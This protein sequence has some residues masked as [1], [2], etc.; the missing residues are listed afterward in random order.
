MISRLLMPLVLLTAVPAHAQ[1]KLLHE[2]I[3]AIQEALV[4][5]GDYDGPLDGSLAGATLTALKQFQ[6]REGAPVKGRVNSADAKRLAAISENAKRE[7]GWSLAIDGASDTVLWIPHAL[8]PN[9][10]NGPDGRTF[11]S[12]DGVITLTLVEA[13]GTLTDIYAATLA[14]PEGKIE[15][16]KLDK[17]R[18]IIVGAE[19]D[20]GFFNFFTAAGKGTKG[21]TFRYPRTMAQ[22]L[23]PVAIA[24]ANG[25]IADPGAPPAKKA[26]RAVPNFIGTYRFEPAARPYVYGVIDV[27]QRGTVV[28]ARDIAVSMS[29]TE[30]PPPPDA[31]PQKRRRRPETDAPFLT[32][33]QIFV[34]G[35]PVLDAASST[36][37]HFA[38]IRVVELDAANAHPEVMLSVYNGGAHCCTELTI[39]SARKDGSWAA[40]D[41]GSFDG[42]PDF[43]RDLDGD[44]VFELV[45]S[46]NA[47]LGAFD[48]Y[49]NSYA[50][51]EI[52]RLSGETLTDVS[53]D[54]RFRLHH[55]V[56]LGELWNWGWQHDR[57]A[58]KG[59]LAGFVAT[60]RRA[61]QADDALAFLVARRQSAKDDEDEPFVDR[62]KTFLEGQQY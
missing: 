7:A 20:R 50:P 10:A 9:A 13:S 40:I 57:L 52:R 29:G 46:D 35:E 38:E 48:D 60:A 28:A 53:A 54:E 31:K 16:E 42:S 44:G 21:F 22:E 6:A 30:P 37:T 43:P 19:G 32:N 8:L 5:S 24:M 17:T 58:D 18:A 4:W 59:F 26:V 12:A 27:E 15:Q 23:K 39:Y 56:H 47:F 51:V 3:M 1:D 14:K 34:A 2:N 62:L 36:L 49:A 33:I 45:N 61:G 55:R 11:S 41:G 25:L